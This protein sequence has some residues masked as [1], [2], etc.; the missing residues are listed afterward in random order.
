[1]GYYKI[2]MSYRYVKYEQ[3][4]CP[5]NVTLYSFHVEGNTSLKISN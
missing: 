3:D 5:I 1:M 4:D 2:Y